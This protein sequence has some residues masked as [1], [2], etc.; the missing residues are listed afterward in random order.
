MQPAMCTCKAS[1]YSTTFSNIWSFMYDTMPLRASFSLHNN[2][3]TIYMISQIFV[4]LINMNIPTH[5]L[6]SYVST[7]PSRQLH[8]KP[9][10]KSVHVCSHPPLSSEHSNISAHKH[11]TQQEIHYTSN[12]KGKKKLYEETHKTHVLVKAP[13]RVQYWNCRTRGVFEMR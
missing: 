4:E 12:D 5:V 1:V 3:N 6:L 11:S 9:P 13:S 10:P 8:M 7:N 2:I